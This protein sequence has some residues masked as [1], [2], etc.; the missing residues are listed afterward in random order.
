MSPLS[1]AHAL[2]TLHHLVIVEF[3]V[4]DAVGLDRLD[5][6]ALEVNR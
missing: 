2:S 4:D 6:H 1:V 3:Y 5:H